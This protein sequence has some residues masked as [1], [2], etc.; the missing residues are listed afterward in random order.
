MQLSSILSEFKHLFDAQQL[1][2]V[3]YALRQD[4]LVWK[5]IE[6]DDFFI[7]AAEYCGNQAELWNPATLSLLALEHPIPLDSLTQ[8]PLMPIDVNLR[9]K[10]ARAYEEYFRTPQPTASLAD[11]GLLALALRER[12][13][14]KSNWT[15]ISTEL[16]L[17]ID[18]TGSAWISPLACLIAMLPADDELLQ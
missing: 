9:Q 11:A 18:S 3:L 14:V 7:K 13:R 4:P 15:G 16:P 1:P 10:A 6:K 8:Q 5:E 2:A 12:R 17:T